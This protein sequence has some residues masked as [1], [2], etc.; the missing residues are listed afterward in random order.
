MNTHFTQAKGALV[1]LLALISIGL[2]SCSC[3]NKGTA[4]TAPID[5]TSHI[6][7]DTILAHRLDSFSHALRPKGMFGLAI[8]DLTAQKPV[9]ALADTLAQPSASTLK[10][11]SGVAGLHLLGTGYRYT[12]TLSQRGQVRDGK[13]HGDL[14]LQADMD[15]QLQVADLD[16]MV[17]AL[18]AKGISGLTGRIY[19]SLTLR[20]A[21]KAEEHWYPWDLAFSKYG[22]L[23]KGPEA[24]HRAFKATLRARGIAV[25]DSQM[26]A[27]S[28]PA[29]GTKVVARKQRPISDVTLRIWKN[30]SNT[31][32]TALLYTMGHHTAPQR[33]PE[34]AGVEY[35]RR[36]MTTE[37]GLRD[38]SLSVHDGCGLCT[39]NRLTPRSLIA[40]LRYAYDHKPIFNMLY[41][42]LSIAGVDGSLA[43]HMT[44]PKTRGKIHAKTG[45]LSH[46]YGISSLAGYCYAPN[47]HLLCFAI[48]DSQMSVLDAHVLQQKLCELLVKP[49][50]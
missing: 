43:S 20:E 10:L 27:G 30:S 11:I 48:M 47:G 14:M 12:T 4:N 50:K 2:T 46:P 23:F 29:K 22:I 17:Q 42:Q 1:G 15:P 44:S 8:Y 39:H 37:L 5:S 24:V 21:V 25:A 16:T 13:L 45:T 34:A 7:I 32:A 3:S 38:T 36:F 49:T 28:M 41:P 6:P 19:M 9:Y 31:Q 26:V 35:L 18:K 40:V 33:A